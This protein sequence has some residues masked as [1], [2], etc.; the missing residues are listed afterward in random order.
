MILVVGQA[1]ILH[2]TIKKTRENAQHLLKHSVKLRK[3][4]F[5]KQK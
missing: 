5:V 1:A 2:V 3:L 4:L